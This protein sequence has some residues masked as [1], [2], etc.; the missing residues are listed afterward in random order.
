VLEGGDGG[1]LASE[2]AMKWNSGCK[3]GHFFSLILELN[4]AWI[5]YT[6]IF[7][8]LENKLFSIAFSGIY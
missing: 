1:G 8:S 6:V 2:T 4:R 5:W 3:D 7:L